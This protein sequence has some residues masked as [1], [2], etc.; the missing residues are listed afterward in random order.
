MTALFVLKILHILA[1][2]AWIGGSLTTPRDIRDSLSLGP[3]HSLHLMGR[4]RA[5][6]RLMNASALLTTLSGLALVF[7]LGG[8]SHV[9]H[10]IHAGL[11]LTLAAFAAGRFLIRP[12]ILQI[13]EAAK[14]PLSTDH[15]SK[16]MAKFWFG[17]GIEHALRVVVLVLMV[18]PFAF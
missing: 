11:A 1:A 7:A 15:V 3:P 16:L 18:Y 4:L 8:F 13:A 10:R 17:N 12:A 9:P 14:S 5:V 6:A 2:A